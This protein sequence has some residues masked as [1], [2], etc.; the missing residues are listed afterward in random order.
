MPSIIPASVGMTTST[1]TNTGAAPSINIPIARI[2]V[3]AVPVSVSTSLATASSLRGSALSGASSPATNMLAAS[4]GNISRVP[5]F[6]AGG[7]SGGRSSST[8]SKSKMLTLM[9]KVRY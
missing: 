6:S 3:I 1:S 5:A 7:R 4:R 9:S 8:K 2:G